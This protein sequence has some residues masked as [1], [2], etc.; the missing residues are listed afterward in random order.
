MAPTDDR[1]ALAR[2]FR[3]DVNMGTASV[4]DWQQLLGV[5][6]FMPTYEPRRQ[7][8]ESYEDSGAMRRATTGYAWGVEISL[9]HRTGSAGTTWNAVQ[10]KLR[11]VAEAN[12]TADGEVQVRWYDRNGRTGDNYSGWVLVD[13]TPDGGD[14]GARDIVSVVLHGQGERADLTNPLADLTPIVTSLDPATGLEAGGELITIHGGNFVGVTDVDFGAT[15]ADDFTVVSEHRIVAVAPSGTGTVDVTVVN[16][17]GTSATS[18]D[19][20]YVYT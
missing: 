4:P 9:I 8:D 6:E 15:A 10:E 12:D 18:D 20:E 17:T 19:T 3:I 11:E 13:W 7:D 2:R 14:P 5:Q 16:A 1:T